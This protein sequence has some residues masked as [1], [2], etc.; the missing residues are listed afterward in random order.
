MQTVSKYCASIFLE[1]KHTVI[2]CG[3]SAANVKRV[4]LPQNYKNA[5]FRYRPFTK[6]QDTFSLTQRDSI[7]E[8]R[9]TD[10]SHGGWGQS[11]I[12]D[13]QYE[14]GDYLAKNQNIPKK[15][16]QTFETDEVTDGMWNAIQSWRNS[17][18]EYEHYFFDADDRLAF[19][20]QNFDQEVVNAY[21]DLIPGAFKA[22]L[23]R[24]C[25]LYIEGGV[26]AD[27]DMICTNPLINWI[28]PHDDLI[29]TRDDPMS[30]EWLANGFI[31]S[32]PRNPVFKQ[33]IDQI[34]DN[35]KHK[36]VLS[37]LNITGP[38]LFG[39]I[40]RD[41]FQLNGSW[42]LGSQVLGQHNVKVLQHTWQT[43][44]FKLNG[45]SVLI[46]EYPDK[47]EE[48][49]SIN[50][51]TFYELYQA[52]RVYREIPRQIMY[53]TQN[54]LDTNRYMIKSFK[55]NLDWDLIYY[56]DIMVERWFNS[57][58][59]RI[60]DFYSTLRNGGEKADFF[61][62][63]WLYENGGLYV[64]AD[65]YCNQPLSNWLKDQ[66]LVVGLEA[67]TGD[68]QSQIDFWKNVGHKV[69]VGLVSVA[70]W[71]IAVKPKH[72]MFKGLIE[73]IIANP[74]KNNVLQNT[75]P[76]RFT[77]HVLKWFGTD[78][79]WTKDVIKDKAVCYSINMFGSNQHHSGA[80]KFQNH[81]RPNIHQDIF[82]SHMFAGT[83][84]KTA[85][86]SFYFLPQIPEVNSHNL[87]IWQ[88]GDILKG[89]SRYE[90]KQSTTRF[91]QSLENVHKVVEWTITPNKESS[92]TIKDIS[93]PKYGKYEDWR[94]FIHNDRVWFIVAYI[95]Q[96]WNT[97]QC[98]IDS[99][100]NWVKDLSVEDPSTMNF[101]GNKEVIWEK[102][103]LPFVQDNRLY[104]IYST[105][106]YFE[107]YEI[108]DQWNLTLVKKLEVD[109]PISED[110][111]YRFAK[112]S[113]GG[114][115]APIWLESEGCW[116]YIIHTKIYAE[117]QYNHYRVKLSRDF[118]SIQIEPQPIFHEYQPWPLLFI[119][120]ETNDWLSGGM[121]DRSN[122]ILRK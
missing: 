121:E 116:S 105:T 94:A 6:W 32:V 82:I 2:D 106:P 39:R 13:C 104:V 86:S 111:Y 44:N 56:N 52:N 117:R 5:K 93:T 67:R 11:L 14:V 61:R 58:E 46:T 84:R 89:V 43:K 120:T 108:D 81:L 122:W 80:I 60:R 18:P 47:L 50:V 4:Q 118:N 9:R 29:I 76:G 10:V 112:A 110:E 41:F 74:I 53:T 26:Y 7:L 45:Q 19:I 103:W 95:D 36:R 48:M 15:V 37:Y 21:L 33:I 92:Y 87:T 34:V 30:T 49:K 102:N 31:A 78:H 75:G 85:A 57:Q 12:V 109:S 68:N 51:P 98:I 113:T 90:P 1:T 100:Y 8:V 42:N 22:D 3:T 28:E 35:V 70:N 88:E 101:T 71:T 114:S 79:D 115:S 55:E 63:C 72:K 16:F 59:P 65:T 40:A 73:D 24:Y 96:N 97:H 62:Y 119:T 54:E 91:M 25:V 64:D 107:L 38:E 69:N 27:A 20:K 66:D 83:W 17:N 77:K 23:W 99:D